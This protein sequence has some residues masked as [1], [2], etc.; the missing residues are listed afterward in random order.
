MNKNI[1]VILTLYKT[2]IEKLNNLNFYKKFPLIIF[3]QEGSLE[4]KK[5]IKKI[6]KRNFKYLY[7]KKNIGLSCA[8]NL[9]LK[10]VRSK[11]MVF[12]QPDI[13][14]DDKSILKLVKIFKKDKNIIFVTP[15]I[16]KKINNFKKKKNYL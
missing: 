12:T 13:I 3:E 1:S 9:L 8:S 11:Y 6:L 2:P 4:A 16:S 15:T 14:I 7:S 5:K 10:E